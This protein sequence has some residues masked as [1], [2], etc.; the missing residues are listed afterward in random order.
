MLTLYIIGCVL[1]S[2]ANAS[3]PTPRGFRPGFCYVSRSWFQESEVPLGGLLLLCDCRD[4]WNVRGH[5]A[6]GWLICP[7]AVGVEQT[8]GA[9]ATRCE[10]WGVSLGRFPVVGEGRGPAC[11]WVG[12]SFVVGGLMWWSHTLFGCARTPVCVF[13]STSGCVVWDFAMENDVG[14]CPGA[15][16]DDRVN[17]AGF[18]RFRVGVVYYRGEPTCRRFWACVFQRGIR[19]CG[20]VRHATG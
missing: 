10:S 13:T 4:E 18:G 19:K 17:S 12:W 16:V 14:S 7:F 8:R 20:W 6:S 11:L 5:L 2:E 1:T 9:M 3:I 15:G